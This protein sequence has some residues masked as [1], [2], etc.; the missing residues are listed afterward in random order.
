MTPTISPPARLVADTCCGSIPM[1]FSSR[2][3]YRLCPTCRRAFDGRGEQRPNG[4]WRAVPGG[5]VAVERAVEVA[6]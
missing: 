2:P 6:A 1:R 5:F 4:N 3:V